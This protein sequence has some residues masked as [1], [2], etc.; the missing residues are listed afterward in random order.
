[1]TLQ[2][3]VLHTKSRQEKW[4]AGYLARRGIEHF[5]PT[6]RQTRYH[7]RR[8]AVVAAPMF[9][10]YVFLRG[11]R[12]QA[13]AA[14]RTR[15]LAQIIDVA[16]Q[17]RLAHELGQIRLALSREAEL[18]PHRYLPAGTPAVVRAGPMKGLEGVV[19]G[20]GSPGR[21][22][23]QINTLGQAVGVEL[24]ASLVEPLNSP[25]GTGGVGGAAGGGNP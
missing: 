23:L 14:D 10:G 15:R 18:V 1:M 20:G 11:T 25:A 3:F 16:D 22:V 9:P 13:F 6:L 7:G 21:L 2:W 19:D 17:D 8:P 12:E 5:L 4:V 24:D